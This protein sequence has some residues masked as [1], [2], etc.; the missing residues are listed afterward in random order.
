MAV[1]RMFACEYCG[2]VHTTTDARKRFCN[3]K[4]ADRSRNSAVAVVPE[5]RG[6]AYYVGKPNVNNSYDNIKDLRHFRFLNRDGRQAAL[7]GLSGFSVVMFDIEATHLKPNVGR[8]LCCSFKPIGQDVYTFSALDKGFKKPDVYDDGD[9][10]VAIRD[11]LEKYDIIV[12][13][14]SKNFDV[15]FINSRSIRAGGRTKQAQYHVDG[16]WSWRSKFNAWSGLDNV[17]KFTEPQA[18]TVKT[19]VAWD[20]W[21]RAIGWDPK[22]SKAAM[23]EIVDHCDRDVIV[24][25]DV[26]RKVVKADVVRSLRKDGGIL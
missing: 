18:T 22:L 21:M 12:G 5:V 6:G 4:C 14:N 8:I 23:Q 17:Q 26:Y 15:K 10:A 9:L 1:E 16:M 2:T 13:W 7:L 20:Q 19:S 11:E 25:E 24:L 3:K